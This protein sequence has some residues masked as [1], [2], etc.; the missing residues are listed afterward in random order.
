MPQHGLTTDER[1]WPKVDRSGGPEA[2]WPW[3]AGTT[4]EGYG[5]FKA[6]DRC[7]TAHR[8]AWESAHGAIPEGME[9]DHVRDRGCVRR[10]CCNPTHLEPVTH[11]ENMRRISGRTPGYCK[12][13][14][15]VEG[16]NLVPRADGKRQCRECQ[17][18]T[19]RERRRHGR[20]DGGRR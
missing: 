16:K 10:D 19:A 3:L 2:C 1:F 9:V 11:A 6:H 18:M 12:R 8:Y 20:L 4:S 14:H 15:L 17:N 13:G 5:L 7:T